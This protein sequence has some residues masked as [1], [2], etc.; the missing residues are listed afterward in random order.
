MA[1]IDLSDAV[2]W[3]TRAVSEHPTDLTQAL[4]ARYRVTRAAAAAAV[5]KLEE[6]GWV[7]R[8]GGSTRPVFQQGP[9]RWLQQE[10]AL[11]GIDEDLIWVRDFA[12]NLKLP[13]NVA[14][15]A[16]YGFTEMVNNANDHSQGTVLTA[17]VYQDADW[18]SI[19]IRDNGIGIFRKICD[20]L[21]L[22]DLRLS[23]LELSKGK[24]T[25]DPQ[26]HS[27]EGIFFTSRA[28][29]AFQMTANGLLYER[30]SKQAEHERL[31]EHQDA[32]QGTA[33]QMTLP[34]QSGRT[35]KEV[36]DHYTTGAPEDLSFDKTVIPVRLARLGNENLLSRSQAKRLITRIDR[37]RVV[38]LDFSEVPQI[39]Q[40]FADELFR[41]YANQH[42]EIR[43]IPTN[44]NQEVM[45][46]IG[47]VRA[48]F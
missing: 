40:A 32:A 45:R 13:E 47:R 25:T 22:P 8:S 27:G 3:V 30:A 11:P 2:I 15:I 36:F 4:A 6:S 24:F 14:N 16:H 17:A 23:L 42:P 28:F 35:L 7:Q 21:A 39:G 12:P 48:S 29:D 37:F 9:R 38:E 34:L 26:R 41:V 19:Y 44:A 33:L 1:K 10:Y 18:L 20:A 5:R 43:L 46:M 31:D